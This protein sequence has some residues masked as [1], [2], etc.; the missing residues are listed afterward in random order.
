MFAYLLLWDKVCCP[1][2]GNQLVVNNFVSYSVIK[3][4]QSLL[5]SLII[6]ASKMAVCIV[7]FVGSN[8]DIIFVTH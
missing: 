4:F 2:L 3:Y 5:H 1:F 8:I 6:M 7:R